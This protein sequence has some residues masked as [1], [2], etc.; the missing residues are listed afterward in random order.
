MSK[1]GSK[2][3]TSSLDSST[4]LLIEKELISSHKP[5]CA[6]PVNSNFLKKYCKS[7]CRQNH[8]D[9]CATA[10][11]WC[12]LTQVPPNRYEIYKQLQHITIESETYKKYLEQIEIDL[13]RTYPDIEY[14]TIGLGVEAL[15]RVLKTFV[16]YHYQM[17]YVQGMNYIVC[18]L[19][20]HASEV[21]AF[22]L[23]VILMDEYKLRENYLYRFPG[24]TKHSEISESLIEKY[25]PKLSLHL[26]DHCLMVQLFATDWFLTLFTSLIP[27]QYSD[28]L[29]GNFFK[30]GW[31]F[32]Y[33]LLICILERLENKLLAKND[34][35]DMLSIIKPMELVNN[36]WE[37]FLIS[38]QRKR[39]TI[40]WP[41]LIKSAVRKNIN[42]RLVDK[43][44]SSY[45]MEIFEADFN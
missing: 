23:F 8:P 17:G 14:F 40:T 19:L 26:N 42:A 39:E 16:T 21:D 43:L 15:R 4:L 33:K 27:I 28:K 31:I 34:R 36:D 25:L 41:K 35:L 11:K 37:S 13:T 5:Q 45:R 20:W 29:I 7:S 44:L 2:R 32:I 22:W 30:F 38:L 9:S 3:R 6:C 24:V 1:P 12:H 10:H 18:A